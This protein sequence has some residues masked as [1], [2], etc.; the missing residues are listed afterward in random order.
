MSLASSGEDVGISEIL[1]VQMRLDNVTV[2][3]HP[4][5]VRSA[6][7]CERLKAWIENEF[8]RLVVLYP[9]LGI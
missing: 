3:W 8:A 9:I 2:F 6:I 4:E 5:G 7:A 1:G